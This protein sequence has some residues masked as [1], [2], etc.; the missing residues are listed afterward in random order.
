MRDGF[1][2]ALSH[3]RPHVDGL[4]PGEGAFL[5]CSFWLADNSRA[6]RPARRRAR[7]CSSGCWPCATISACWPRNTIR[8]PSACSAISRKPLPTSASSTQP[9]ISRLAKARRNIARKASRLRTAYSFATLSA[10]RGSFEN[11]GAALALPRGD[12]HHLA[13]TVWPGVLSHRRF[14]RNFTHGLSSRRHES[15]LSV[16][17]AAKPP[18][19]GATSS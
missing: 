19:D 17:S 1:V 9:A 12:A 11:L 10:R 18:L 14:W 4:P 3:R 15:V 7:N 13:P 5:P 8:M 16:P 6:G 2:A